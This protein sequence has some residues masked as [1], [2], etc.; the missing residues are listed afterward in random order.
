G[1]LSDLLARASLPESHAADGIVV[2]GTKLGPLAGTALRTIAMDR[3][4]EFIEKARSLRPIT[5]DVDGPL[6]ELARRRR[7]VRHAASIIEARL[8]AT[9]A[10]QGKFP[11]D[12]LGRQFEVAARLLC[13]DVPT[14]VIKLS[15]GGFDTHTNQA[16]SHQRLLGTLAEGLVAFESALRRSGHWDR[17]L[18][19]T[20][21]E[22]GRRAG[23]N[24]SRGT[25]HGTAAPHFAV[26]GS[27]RGGLHGT[28]PSLT[29]LDRG[30]LKFTVDYRRLYATI[31][32]RWWN[33]PREWV[34]GGA[35]E[36]I[37]LV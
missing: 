35:F 4:S 27:V 26:G 31:A 6:G 36:P 29:D 33:L 5:N 19:L 8:A 9:E 25:D 10:P 7:D 13:S 23:E 21:S 17:V 1:W 11:N 20:Y 32:H 16:G 30:D 2:G 28:T 14:R 24:G 37:D 18:V 15:I 3:P 22:F 12:R 34:E